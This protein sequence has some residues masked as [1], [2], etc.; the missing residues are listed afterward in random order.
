MGR[1]LVDAGQACVPELEA[2]IS[3]L[4]DRPVEAVR[5]MLWLGWPD[6]TLWPAAVHRG[7]LDRAAAMASDP[8]VL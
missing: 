8:R 5:A 1:V 6:A 3:S 2:V 4:G 7:W